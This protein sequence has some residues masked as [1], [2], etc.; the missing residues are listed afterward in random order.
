MVAAGRLEREHLRNRAPLLRQLDV[1][2][3]LEAATSPGNCAMPTRVSST[4]CA[5]ICAMTSP[6]LLTGQTDHHPAGLPPV[7][8]ASIR[9]L[10][11]AQHPP[12]TVEGGRGRPATRFEIRPRRAGLTGSGQASLSVVANDEVGSVAAIWPM[13]E[14]ECPVVPR[15]CRA[16]R[17][18]VCAATSAAGRRGRQYRKRIRAMRP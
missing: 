16:Q 14:N 5:G 9:P 4:P 7:A 12:N 1:Q 3:G 8:A 17:P 6:S 13:S 18:A 2:L 10:G 11:S 15:A